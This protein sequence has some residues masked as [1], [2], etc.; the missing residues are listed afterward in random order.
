[1]KEEQDDYHALFSVQKMEAPKG[2]IFGT[3]AKKERK[4]D[5]FFGALIGV[6]A[7]SILIGLLL[8]MVSC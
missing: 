2:I 3:R 7:S 6:I 8:K 1:M 4:R 5:I